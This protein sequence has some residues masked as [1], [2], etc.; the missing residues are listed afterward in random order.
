MN[1]L[2][3]PTFHK[4]RYVLREPP[5]IGG[6]GAEFQNIDFESPSRP[7]EYTLQSTPESLRNPQ[8]SQCLRLY[9]LRSGAVLIDN[10]NITRQSETFPTTLN[11][12]IPREIVIFESRVAFNI[13]LSTQSTLRSYQEEVIKT[14]CLMSNEYP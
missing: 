5:S 2:L 12:I 14:I 6:I 8:H 7:G 3:A 13:G 1:G 4:S 10:A 11:A 9:C